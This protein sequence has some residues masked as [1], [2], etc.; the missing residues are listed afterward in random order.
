MN[1]DAVAEALA[2]AGFLDT[3]VLSRRALL[4]QAEA[5]LARLSARP[6]WRFLVPGR[7]EVL[8][9]HTDYGGGRTLVAAVPR[10]FAVAAAPRGDR[11]VRAYDARNDELCEID[12]D[13][14]DALRGWRSYVAVTARRL[15][16]NFPGADLGADVG[17]A[18]DLPRAAGMSSSSAL[19]IAIASVLIRRGS[20]DARADWMDVLP[21]TDHRVEY[22]GCIENGDSYRVLPGARGVG[23]EGGS[24][25]HAAIV[26][27]RAGRLSHFSF[28]PLERLSVVALP[29]AWTFVVASSGVH[30]DKAGSVR[31]RYN[32]AAR[33]LRSLLDVWRSAAG[34]PGHSL[35]S[36]LSTA[37]DA[38]ARLRAALAT[39]TVADF[40][41][42]ELR[43]RLDHFV[44][45]N[46]RVPAAVRAFANGDAALLGDLSSASQDD[47]DQLL[48]N[49]VE[50]TN[51]L[52]DM[53]R[54]RGAFAA[55]GFGAGFGGSVWAL[56]ETD[57]ANDFASDW[58][59][60]Y[61]QRYPA[62]TDARVFTA[63]PAPGLLEIPTDV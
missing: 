12:L 48:G 1:T 34:E 41:A 56:I 22:F 45:E 16:S 37:P 40:T 42:A 46:A 50:E 19:V 49:Q 11:L 52:V 38:E 18:S 7:L 9:K 63:R 15:A 13:D 17:F 2:G 25:D 35:A 33:A 58:L 61:I 54:E 51:T 29:E 21:S 4:K 39:S 3:D 44:R 31:T 23:T 47:A 28:M 27:S 20:L 57:A 32:R 43:R 55:S 26:M 14:S 36:T 60:A 24:E 8:G 30:A 6:R 53:A 10:G 59:A 5:G 62:R